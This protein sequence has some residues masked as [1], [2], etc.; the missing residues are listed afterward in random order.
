MHNDVSYNGYN[1]ATTYPGK[2]DYEMVITGEDMNK[3]SIYLCYLLVSTDIPFDTANNDIDT[4]IIQMQKYHTNTNQNISSFITLNN[5]I[6]KCGNKDFCIEYENSTKRIF[7][8]STTID[9]C[10]DS[11]AI[12]KSACPTNDCGL[13]FDSSLPSNYVIIKPTNIISGFEDEQIYINCTPTGVSQDEIKTY[14]I[15]INSELSQQQGELNYAKSVVDFFIF[16]IALLFCYAVVPILYK[17]SVIDNLNKVFKDSNEEGKFIRHTAIDVII[18]IMLAFVSMNCFFVGYRKGNY[19][20]NTI[21]VLIF[22][23]Y[24]LSFSI[25][26]FKYKEKEESFI[27]TLVCGREITLNYNFKNP[28]EFDVLLKETGKTVMDWLGILM[29]SFSVFFMFII[30]YST[31]I[32]MIYILEMFN[33]NTN[34][35][36]SYGDNIFIVFYISII[37]ISG[38]IPM[39]Y[40]YGGKNNTDDTSDDTKNA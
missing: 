36:T 13:L 10:S 20:I 14:N 27:T 25:I 16:L 1:L 6:P 17:M 15:P 38:L 2:L 18:T 11:V 30:I 34:I 39:F 28:I 40:S 12:L 7:V 5:C 24:L 37:L 23:Y 26:Q 31:V 29:D 33:S 19:F 4:M 22:I 21:G 3:N 8:F 32:I 9:I 35:F